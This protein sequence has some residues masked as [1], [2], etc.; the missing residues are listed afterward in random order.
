MRAP[1][2]SVLRNKSPRPLH[3]IGR[4]GVFFLD[5]VGEHVGGGE[6]NRYVQLGGLG[7]GLRI[8]DGG[9]EG[10]LQGLE[11]VGGN[12]GRRR[13]GAAEGPARDQEVQILALLFVGRERR[14]RPYLGAVV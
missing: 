4:R 3:H 5:R 2:D 14:R 13:V 10:L 8:V 12:S 6:S 1:P 9:G 11:P 7:S